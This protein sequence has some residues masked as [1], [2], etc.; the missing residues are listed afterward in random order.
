V[1]SEYVLLKIGIHEIKMAS[2]LW[3]IPGELIHLK[4]PEIRQLE[5]NKVRGTVLG[6]K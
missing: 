2:P 1:F 6:R 3:G 5:V 4:Q